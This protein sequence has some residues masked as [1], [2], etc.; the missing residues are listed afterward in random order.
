MHTCP[1]CHEPGVTT[2]AKLCSGTWMPATCSKCHGKSHAH[3]VA[4]ALF[5]AV[6]QVSFLLL[7]WLA[8]VMH[9]WL[10]LISFFLAATFAGYGILRWVPL[11]PARPALVKPWRLVLV[12][13]AAV[14][15]FFPAFW[16]FSAIAGADAGAA[17]AVIT[18]LIAFPIASLRLGSRWRA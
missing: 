2:W 12:A 11:V 15:L 4:T 13:A 8:L 10:P 14:L 16:I 7:G 5:G 1:L 9:S 6:A 18:T 3:P 17:A